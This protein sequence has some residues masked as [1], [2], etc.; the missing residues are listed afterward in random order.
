MGKDIFN[1]R[2]DNLV[3]FIKVIDEIDEF[4]ILTAM[5]KFYPTIDIHKGNLYFYERHLILEALHSLLDFTEFE[6]HFHERKARELIK[7]LTVDP[8]WIETTTLDSPFIIETNVITGERRARMN[9]ISATYSSATYSHTSIYD[10]SRNDLKDS[11]VH[12][13]RSLDETEDKT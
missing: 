5:H 4:L 13:L 11:F 12:I 3:N 1:M 10:E 9:K 6:K 2:K 7:K 8:E